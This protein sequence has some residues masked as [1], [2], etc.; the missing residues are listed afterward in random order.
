VSINAAP[1]WLSDFEDMMAVFAA[2]FGRVEPRRQARS[3]LLGLLSP[4]ADRNGWTLAE[5]AGDRT[6]DQTQR[7]LNAAR[8]DADAVRDHLRG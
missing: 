8:W 1:G 5:A 2:R 4:L 3:Y 6:P 7:L